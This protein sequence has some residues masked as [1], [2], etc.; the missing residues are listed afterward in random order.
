LNVL[1]DPRVFNIV[2]LALFGLATI[3]WAFAE[4]W[5]QTLYFAGAF[6]LNWAVTF[7]DMK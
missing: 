6:A 4:N 3:R 2:L 5:A 1:L 7:G